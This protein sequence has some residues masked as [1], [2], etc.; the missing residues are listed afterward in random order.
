MPRLPHRARLR[1][2]FAPMNEQSAVITAF[3][4]SLVEFVEAVLEDWEESQ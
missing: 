3:L 4:V 1:G 2:S